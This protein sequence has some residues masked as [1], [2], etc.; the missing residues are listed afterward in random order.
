MQHSLPTPLH[1]YVLKYIYIVTFK[2]HDA[3]PVTVKNKNK[4]LSQHI[5][6][7]TNYFCF[8][9]I[10]QIS[11]TFVLGKTQ[12]NKIRALANDTLQKMEGEE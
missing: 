3:S 4:K 8:D 12:L 2:P 6:M 10:V 9:G 11:L 7:T 1:P 5:K